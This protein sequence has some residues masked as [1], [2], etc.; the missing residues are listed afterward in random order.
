MGGETDWFKSILH[1]KTE[2]EK[3]M[4]AVKTKSGKWKCR[5]VDHYEYVDG[6]RKVVL[7]CVTADTKRKAL[8]LAYDYERDRKKAEP[9][10]FGAALQ[11]YIDLKRQVLSATTIA[12]GYESIQR[13]AFGSISGL[14][15]DAI[16]SEIIQAWISEYSVNHSAKSVAN[17]HGLLM[18][19]MSMFRP[20]ARFSVSLPKRNPPQLYTP[21]DSDIKRLLDH[22][23]GTEIEK[24]VLLSAFGT[25][26]RGEL[27]AITVDDVNGDVI[28]VNK[29]LVKDKNGVW[30]VKAPKT[31]DSVRTVK[32]PPEVIKRVVRDCAPSG[33]LL[34]LTP[35]Q[36]TRRFPRILKKCGLPPFRFHDLRAYAVSI[37]HALGIPDQY[38]MR[39]G[40]YKTDFV[41][42]QIYRRT[43]ADKE[44]KFD[45]KIN[46]HFAEM[47]R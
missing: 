8:E 42:K 28:T 36:I 9:I 10:T 3:T 29:S 40:G 5:P 2:G 21:T 26:R 25:L 31:P 45:E 47:L 35:D 23:A 11:K 15:L 13:N 44:K 30:F 20:A 37:R 14:N 27:C 18:A 39:D 34:Q 16:T 7:G 19:V 33:M 1:Q 4:K 43:M 32:Y 46:S 22:I 24:A 17:A 12:R 38:I 6:K 41:M